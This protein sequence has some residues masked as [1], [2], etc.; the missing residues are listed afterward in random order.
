MKVLNPRSSESP[1]PLLVLDRKFRFGFFV[2]FQ[3]PFVLYLRLPFVWMRW[4][5]A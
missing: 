2:Q 4:G 1:C 5:S 3:S